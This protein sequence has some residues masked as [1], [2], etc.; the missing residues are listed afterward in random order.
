[1]NGFMSVVHELD[2]PIGLD[3]ILHTPDGDRPAF[4]SPKLEA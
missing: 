3:L 4:F 2:R 1:M